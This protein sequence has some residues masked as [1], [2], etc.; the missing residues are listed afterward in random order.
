MLT[1]RGYHMLD[2]AKQIVNR[3]PDI[4]TPAHDDWAKFHNGPSHW[5]RYLPEMLCCTDCAGYTNDIYTK[6]PSDELRGGNKIAMKVKVNIA[7]I[8]LKSFH[9]MDIRILAIS[10][11]SV[12]FTAL[13][14]KSKLPR[15][16]FSQ[17]QTAAYERCGVS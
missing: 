15:C 4:F 17:I 2:K 6:E 13:V 5:C 14:W 11:G 10:R 12:P 3:K 7:L 1:S 9:K 8:I 16:P